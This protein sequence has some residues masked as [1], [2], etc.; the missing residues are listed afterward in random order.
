MIVNLNRLADQPTQP[1]RPALRIYPSVFQEF[2]DPCME[3]FAIFT[4]SLLFIYIDHAMQ[5]RM[6]SNGTDLSIS[7]SIKHVELRWIS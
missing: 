7:V 5:M 2:V 1:Q 3:A 4:S 6:R